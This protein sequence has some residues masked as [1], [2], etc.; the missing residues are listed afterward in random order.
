MLT[1]D[2]IWQAIDDLAH[3]NKLSASGLARKA[4][5]DPTSF[6]KSKRQTTSGRLRWPSTESIAKALSATSTS[7]ESFMSLVAGEKSNAIASSA[8]P[9]FSFADRVEAG[10]TGNYRNDDTNLLSLSEDGGSNF[11]ANGQNSP[12]IPLIGFAKAGARGYFDNG[13]FPAGQGWDMVEFPKPG[14]D[15]VYALEVSGDGML[16]LYREG[17]ILVVLPA[18]QTKTGD[19]VVL[20]TRSGEVMAKILGH[21]D[22]KHVELQSLDSEHKTRSFQ[23]SEIDWIARILWA[24]Q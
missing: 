3:M 8:K 20:K 16:P 10:F 22:R 21:Q 17:D 5:L 11:M 18:T 12:G 9:A 2:K 24:S 7:L 19:R 14:V 15:G 23:M 4:G 6:N 1:H 13:G